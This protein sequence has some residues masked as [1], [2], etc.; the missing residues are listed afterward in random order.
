MNRYISA[1][2]RFVRVWILG[3]HHTLA[4][5]NRRPFQF[6]TTDVRTALDRLKGTSLPGPTFRANDVTD[7]GDLGFVADP[8][9]YVED[10]TMHLFF[11][12]FSPHRDP[13]AAIGHA[14]SDDEGESWTYTGLALD[15][16]HHLSFPYVFAA[17]DEIYMVPDIAN[18]G[19]YRAPARLYRTTAFPLKWEPV[20]DIIIGPDK[21][22]DTVVFQWGSRWWAITGTGSNDELSVY[23][24]ETLT[25][26]GWTPHPENPVVTDRPSAGR[27]AGRPLVREDSIVAFFQDCTAEYGDQLRAYE[28]TSLDT[29]TYED[30]PLSD[31][32]L[33]GGTG[34]LGWNSGRMHH[35]DLQSVDG[36][37]YC[38]YDGDVGIGR[39]RVSGSMWSIGVGTTD[40]TGN[41]Q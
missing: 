4:S 26:P 30:R 39:N 10:R 19:D 16:D 22:Q 3:V 14:V 20:T 27:P 21:Y 6:G 2:R 12:V 25:T 34:G 9:L 18:S 24:S 40:P 28:I 23:Y 37:I 7:H 35:L 36:E 5:R 15:T 8:F 17:N 13:T 11:E 32:A 38:A 41:S 29:L 31:N 1:L 33:L